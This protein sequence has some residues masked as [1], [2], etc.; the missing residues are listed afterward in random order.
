[1]KFDNVISLGGNCNIALNLKEL[2]FRKASYPFDWLVSYDVEKVV[3][4][5]ENDFKGFLN[6]QNLQ[7]YSNNRCCY[8]DVENDLHFYHDF[9]QYLSLRVQL[10]KVREKYRRRIRRFYMDITKPTLFVRYILIEDD[11][12]NT[13]KKCKEIDD[14]L[15][16]FNSKNQILYCS[17]IRGCEKILDSCYYSPKDEN[18]WLTTKPILKN[19]NFKN[20]LLA[21]ENPDKYYNLEFAKREEKQIIELSTFEII[22]KKIRKKLSR[23]YIHNKLYIDE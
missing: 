19:E 22:Q 9:D 10:P 16:S 5:I 18:S 21:L 3:F 6:Y 7:Q 11:L 15:K 4:L 20:Y 8:Y 17:H 23:P 12:K 1:M 14:F 2:G 13:A